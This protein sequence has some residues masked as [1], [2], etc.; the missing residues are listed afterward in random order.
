MEQIDPEWFK[1]VEDAW[2]NQKRTFRVGQYPKG[3]SFDFHGAYEPGYEWV[4]HGGNELK[5][6]LEWAKAWKACPHRHL[7]LSLKARHQGFQLF[8]DRRPAADR[9]E[10]LQFGDVD[11]I[12]SD[13]TAM[14]QSIVRFDAMVVS[15]VRFLQR[16]A[17]HAPG[18][19]WVYRH[20]LGGLCTD[21]FLSTSI[22]DRY[23]LQIYES[24]PSLSALMNE[25]YKIYPV[26]VDEPDRADAQAEFN[27]VR[28][29]EEREKQQDA[30]QL[31]LFAAVENA[32]FVPVL[33][34]ADQ[35]WAFK[36]ER[37]LDRWEMM[38]RVQSIP[39]HALHPYRV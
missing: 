24:L 9:N 31:A 18:N 16:G 10:E 38:Q 14:T 29:K 23:K 6:I 26:V 1:R 28:A 12:A 17:D 20:T 30:S 37:K 8:Q 22:P 27:K 33:Y 13:C 4:G 19:S 32:R 36:R 11:R 7:Y 2:D 15:M 34:S 25:W 21:P 39:F 3:W 5:R 35:I